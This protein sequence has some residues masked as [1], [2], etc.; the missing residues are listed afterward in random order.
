MSELVETL[1]D[2]FSHTAAH[3]FGV[4]IKHFSFIMSQVYG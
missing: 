3:I 2:W 1:E 4:F